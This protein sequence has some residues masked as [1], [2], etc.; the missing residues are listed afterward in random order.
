MT[1]LTKRLTLAA[2]ATITIAAGIW[3]AAMQAAP[4]RPST[5]AAD[6]PP[7]A[8]LTIETP[9]FAALLRSWNSS[10]EQADWLHS[11]N[12]SNFAN[13]RLLSRLSDAQ[14][15]FAGVA[16]T[17]GG[18]ESPFLNQVA[19]TESIFAWYDIA[20]LEF[21]YI[22]RLPTGRTANIELLQQ[23]ATFS[24]RE[25]GGTTFYVKTSSGTATSDDITTPSTPRTIAF[26]TRGDFLLLATREDLMAN[27][28][29]L[30]QQ[31]SATAPSEAT[32]AWY[33]AAEAA[34]P[35]R[36]GDLH[37]L[38]DLQR[39]TATPQFRTYWIQHNVT[40]TRQYRAA[41]VDLY[42]DPRTFREERV[43][44]PMNAADAPPQPD[45]ASLE[46]LVP[47]RAGVYRA[48]GN[49]TPAAALASLDEKLL[50]RSTTSA[51][52]SLNAPA[53]DLTITQPGSNTDLETRIDTAN[54]TPE[55]PSAATAPLLNA[56]QSAG[57][58]AMLTLDRTDPP[59]T[60][61]LFVP[62]HSAVILR[63]ATPWNTAQL[64]SAILTNLSAHLT[65]STLGLTWTQTGN[66]FTLNDTTPLFLTVDGATAILTNNQPLLTEILAHRAT[67]PPQPAQYI[68]G[69]RHTQERANFTRL[70]AT[71]AHA[72][73]P[74][75]P[76]ATV[77]NTP[78]V[79]PDF[80]SGNLNSLSE[81]FRTFAT[82]R[83]VERR[84]GANIRQTVTY[85][86][87]TP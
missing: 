42:R 60:G 9:N 4:S 85:T 78:G 46:A 84:D 24:R 56:L 61:S 44:L 62:I 30:M 49:P 82:E 59:D 74:S 86:L 27:A 67:A 80:F 57:L 51:A 25:S 17:K 76:D 43:L 41:V 22:T 1:P 8:L 19:G 36:H 3:A 33:A 47:D 55:P 83:L 72:P 38:L 26:A 7:G 31:A 54:T 45:L 35:A 23:H 37:M 58:T 13:S 20:N 21:L 87:A 79:V 2:V 29:A 48:L 81:A 50:T 12:Y 77:A 63:S 40:D 28:L 66:T 5:L 75:T 34:G 64:Q 70:T 16:A 11:A 65:V 14:A 69:F 39:I 32:E 18:L 71:L 68:A 6:L 53:A 73:S 52:P 10:P 15:E